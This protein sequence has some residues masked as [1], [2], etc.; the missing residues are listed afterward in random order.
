MPPPDNNGLF[1]RILAHKLSFFVVFFIVFLVSYG[2]LYAVDFIPEA[3]EEKEEPVPAVTT[4]PEPAPLVVTDPYPKRMII[5]ALEKDIVIQNPES[6][7]VADLDKALLTG[8]VRHPDSA[9][10]AEDGTMFLFGHSSY[11]PH[12]FN[13]NF[14]A[15]N[16]VQKLVWGDI[17]KVQSSNVEYRYRVNKVYKTKAEDASVTLGGTKKKLTLVTCNS[18]GSKDERFVVEADLVETV[19]LA[20]NGSP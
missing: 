16:D 18:F 12:V 6:R 2:V 8:A 5:E 1:E 19:A 3:P 10:F 11:L 4:D 14:Q 17:I 13:K 7:T 20:E 15:F 9:T